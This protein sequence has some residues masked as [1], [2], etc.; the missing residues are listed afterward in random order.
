MGI[1]VPTL[2]QH[3]DVTGGGAYNL[4]KSRFD[5]S[6]GFAES[7]FGIAEEFIAQLEEL[8]A[9]FVLPESTIDDVDIPDLDP[10]S[11]TDRPALGDLALPSIPDSTVVK[12]EWIPIPTFATLEFPDF[13]VSPPEYESPEKPDHDIIPP[14]G[15][16]PAISDVEYPVKPDITIP[17][18]PVLADIEFPSPPS[19]TLPTFEGVVPTEVWNLPASFSY[20]EPSYSS[21]VWADLLSKVLNDIRNGGTGLGAIVEEE[22]YD[23]ALARQ[24][25]ENERLYQETEDYFEARGHDLPPGALAG[26]L[27][28]AGREISRSNTRLNAEIMINQA[29]LAQKNT[30]FMVDKGIQLEG[31]LRDFF[32]AQ[33]N[34]AFEASKL[35]AQI[36]VDIFNAQVNKFNGRVAAYQAQAIVYESRV[37]AAL[38]QVE[39]YKGQIEACKVISDVQR[40]LVAIY[41]A[42]VESLDTYIKL[43]AT[44]MEATKIKSEIERSKLDVFRLQV[45]T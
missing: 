16:T 35:I 30:Q 24:E 23:R 25:T 39:I 15:D 17:T 36:G 11:Y 5:L 8:L 29:E 21:D 1:W 20:S 9:T 18:A 32:N 34:R 31:I 45:Q 7:S 26:R 4:V 27:F 22:L 13:N 43:Y 37:K 41:T 14:L 42:R 28:E 12:P 38:T 10:L 6:T 3:V 33:A 40:N 2:G 44:E 19:I